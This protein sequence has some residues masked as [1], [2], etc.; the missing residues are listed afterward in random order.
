MKA[1]RKELA[2]QANEVI[3]VV[4]KHKSTVKENGCSRRNPQGRRNGDA[5]AD[6]RRGGA[7]HPRGR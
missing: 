1:K 6:S 3:R 7:S 5:G 4:T 2:Q